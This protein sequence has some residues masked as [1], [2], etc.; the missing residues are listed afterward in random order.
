MADV[1]LFVPFIPR[2]AR[3]S[4]Q[5]REEFVRFCREEL[6]AFGEA[7]DFDAY[8]WDV[9]DSCR[10]RG[11]GAR[12]F[13]NFTHVNTVAGR[14]SGR[15]TRGPCI[16]P[17]L[18]E[19]FCAFAKA[20]IRFN[21][22]RKRPPVH[23]ESQIIPF[24]ILAQALS[25]KGLKP[26]I[27]LV[28]AHVLN[29]AM[30]LARSR[31]RNGTVG[32]IG[33]KLAEIA[34]FLRTK[35]LSDRIPIAWKHG[36]PRDKMRN[37]RIGREADAHRERKLPSMEVLDAIPQAYRL[38]K[39]KRDVILTSILALL[40]CAPDRINEVLALPEN[41]EVEEILD[42]RAAYALRWP[43]SKGHPDHVKLILAIMVDVAKDAIGRLRKHTAEARQIAGWYE[44]NPSMLYLPEACAHLRGRDLRNSDIAEITGMNPRSP[45]TWTRAAGIK[46]AGTTRA[47]AG[48]PAGYEANVY[49]FADVERAIVAL[50]PDGFPIFD[51]GSGLKYSQAMMVVRY[52]E[53]F[54]GQKAPWRCMIAPV[55]YPQIKVGFGCNRGAARSVF[56]RLGISTAERPIGL[57]SHQI[58][59]YLNTI[60][61]KSNASQVDIAA[62]SGRNDIGQNR[63]YDHETAEDILQRRRRMESLAAEIR[64]SHDGESLPITITPNPPVSKDHMARHHAHGHVTE[65]GFCEHDFASAPCPIF[66]ECLHCTKHVCI[67]GYDPMQVEKVSGALELGRRS[68]AKSMEAVSMDYEGAKDWMQAHTETVTRLTQLLA[69]LTDPYIPDGSRIVLAKGGQYTLVEQ[70][71]RDHEQATGV[72]LL[73]ARIQE[74]L[75]AIPGVIDA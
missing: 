2:S 25:E 29:H 59:H 23:P 33:Y 49:R 47:P 60:A 41:C 42:G 74:N 11:K 50:L 22:S 45:K 57:R 26:D 67:K 43:G 17:P 62:W 36:V 46:R 24:R 13:I 8:S 38:A 34:E 71:I 56:E 19:P 63:A 68:L 66:M 7:L 18:P 53:F 10:I 52:N 44:A 35:F 32:F 70:A 3:N 4:T 5:N 75:N 9:S 6:T 58:R 72:Q 30:L 61:N 48:H 20:Y 14:E 51:V 27:G 65:I 15:G 28:D 16:G 31:Y 21:A 54:T 73:P 37:S 64:I 12:T 39:E 69:V 55:T 40:C 1:A